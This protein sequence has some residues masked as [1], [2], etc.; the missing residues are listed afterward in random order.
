MKAKILERETCVIQNSKDC[1]FFRK[2]SVQSLVVIIIIFVVLMKNRISSEYVPRM[3]VL[4]FADMM[5]YHI[6]IVE[7]TQAQCFDASFLNN[8]NTAMHQ[9]CQFL[10]TCS[11]PI[12]VFVKTTK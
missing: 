10:A 7:N 12:L 2:G 11:K 9:L 6:V 3:K 5:Y 8:D 4:T 1:R